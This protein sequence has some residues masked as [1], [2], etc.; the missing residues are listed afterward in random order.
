MALYKYC[1]S[2]WYVHLDSR[3]NVYMCV[4]SYTEQ[5]ESTAYATVWEHEGT[6]TENGSDGCLTLSHNPHNFCTVLSLS[7][8]LISL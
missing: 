2:L 4:C 8:L 7:P 5:A 6:P 3:I 1:L